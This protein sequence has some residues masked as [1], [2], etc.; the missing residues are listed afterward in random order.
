MAKVSI[1]T[2]NLNNKGG[3][4]KTIKSV[5]GQIYSDIEYIVIDGGSIDGSIDIILQNKG[6]ITKWVSE[7]DTGI[8]N[9]MNKGLNMANGEYCLFL[10]SGDNLVD[11]EIIAKVL[12]GGYSQDILYGE[13][14]FN[15][16]GGRK[17]IQGRPEKLDL[18]FL[19]NDNIW[20]P[21]TFIKRS[22]L[23][24]VGGYDEKYKIA[25]DYDFFFNAIAIKKA[26]YLYLPY[27]ITVYDTM[28]VSSLPKNMPA[29]LSE[30]ALVHKTYLKEDEIKYQDNQKKYKRRGLSRWLVNKP[31]TTR[32]VDLLQR[33][34]RKV[35]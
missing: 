26:S 15:F 8:F 14:I 6:K 18:P 16:G 31:V 9:A 19:Y 13:L 33:F 5:I 27:P 28:G 1:I 34:Y 25:G 3:L 21:A 20:H 24:S 12:G 22:L 29:I 30:R 10:N 17:E 2:I 7:R 35:F 32:I 23:Q 4:E 11:P